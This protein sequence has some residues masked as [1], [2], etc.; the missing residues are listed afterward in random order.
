MPDEAERKE[1][2][3]NDRT[4][5]PTGA[6]LWCEGAAQRCGN[7]YTKAQCD[8]KN[9]VWYENDNCENHNNDDIGCS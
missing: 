8:S 9:G 3:I 2:S 5:T 4:P 6:C 1:T 7:G